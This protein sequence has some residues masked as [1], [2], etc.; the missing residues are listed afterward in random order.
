M[1]HDAG[2]NP[3]SL[4]RGLG[5][6]QA[7]AINITQIVGAGVFLT[8]PVILKEL[9]G[10]YGI[11][12]WLVAGLLI[13]CDGMI[14]AELGA[15]LPSS[16]GSYHFLRE[17][18]GKATWGRLASFLFVWQIL[19]SGPLEVGSGLVAAAQ[20]ST[21]LSEPYQRYDKDHTISRELEIGD[22]KTIGVI[23]SPSRVFGIALGLLMI[24]ILSRRVTTLGTVSLIF[25]IGVIGIL[26]WVL[27]EGAIRFQP[28]LAFEQPPDM[29]ATKFGLALGAGMALAV[30]SY[31]GYYNVCYLGGEVRNPSRTIPRAILT[32]AVAVVIVYTLFHLAVTGVMAP[33]DAVN[34]PDNLIAEFMKRIRGDT[35]AQFVTL[36]LVG[37]CF[38]SAFSGLFGYSRVPYAAAMDGNFFR[39]FAAVHPRTH[40]P[41]RSLF[42]VGGLMLVWSLFSLQAII[43]ALIATRI[44]EQFVLQILAVV[45]LRRSGHPMPW[46]MW[47]YP[48]PCFVALIGW[49]FLYATTGRVFV[50]IGAITLLIGAV[51]FFARAKRNGEWPFETVRS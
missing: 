41:H 42:L 38:A 51:V 6:W 46:R 13:I 37:S 25:L 1:S 43:D 35:A 20:F 21:A 4:E 49:L 40:I 14:W 10:W 12:A 36:C 5:F 47:L 33:S 19:I 8:I 17:S 28:E 45:V 22:N 16:G 39:W 2:S 23:F 50:I 18:F 32:S 3:P 31:L 29:S 27:L 11:L 24:A 48:V 30:Y 44:L 34:Y 7:T 26:A 15:A 9:P